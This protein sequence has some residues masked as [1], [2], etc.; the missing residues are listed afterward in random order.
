MK[1]SETLEDLSKRYEE[2]HEKKYNALHS[3][4]IDAIQSLS[5]NNDDELNNIKSKMVDLITLFAKKT[6]GEANNITDINDINILLNKYESNN[7]NINLK[8]FNEKIDEIQSIKTLIGQNTSS[9]ALSIFERLTNL[10]NINLSS[11][12]VR[13]L[14]TSAFKGESISAND[15]LNNYITP[16]IYVCNTN[17]TARTLSN[18]PTEL[19][20]NLIVLEHA[21]DSVRQFLSIYN[22]NE[23]GNQIWTR[24]FYDYTNSWSNWTQIYGEHNTTKL[25]MDVEFSDGTQKTYTILTTQ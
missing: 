2:W 15:D 20:F 22:T 5:D 23:N 7:N 17:A 13:N 12:N 21:T 14:I 1:I 4:T 16:G 18:C 10:E 6:D 8:T 11:E 9:S 24:N 25:Q 19:A 3:R